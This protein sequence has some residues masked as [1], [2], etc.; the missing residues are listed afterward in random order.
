M[1]EER[2]PLNNDTK[3]LKNQ[4]TFQIKNNIQNNKQL[5]LD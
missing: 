3:N 5:K 4:S 1:T 2:F